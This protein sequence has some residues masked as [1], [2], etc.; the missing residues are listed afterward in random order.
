MPAR[1][2]AADT[3]TPK[4]ASVR[5]I[6][7][8]G[9][10]G[11]VL[12]GN[13]S[14]QSEDAEYD[15]MGFYQ[16]YASSTPSDPSEAW[17]L[18]YGGRLYDTWWASLPVDPPESTHPAY[19]PGSR[20]RGAD[21][22]RCVECHGWDYRGKDGIYGAGRH[23]TGIKGVAAMAGASPARIAEIIRDK[24]HRYTPEIIPDRALAALALFVSKGQVDSKTIIDPLTRVVRGDRTRGRKVFQ[25]LCAI[26]HGFTGQA[27]ITGEDDDLRTLAGIASDNPWRAVHKVMN[28]QTYA[29]M[30][31]MRAFDLQTALDVLSYAQTLP[32][33]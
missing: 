31:A 2:N 8:A 6:L 10:L 26:C 12:P 20:Y 9:L 27:W 23:A 3:A 1:Q 5:L 7:L 30:P 25:N 28:G 14:A 19:P 29:D 21:T 16:S 4:R 11:L 32:R 18:A 15:D 13:A 17:L 33:D 24:T 22:W